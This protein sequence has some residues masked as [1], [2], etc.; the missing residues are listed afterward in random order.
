MVSLHQSGMLYKHDGRGCTN[1][2]AIEEGRPQVLGVLYA[3]LCICFG[4]L[5][6]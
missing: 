6:C 1:E 5:Q 4:Q 3:G 2:L